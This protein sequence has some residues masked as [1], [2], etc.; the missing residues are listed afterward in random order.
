MKQ[1]VRKSFKFKA[2]FRD[3]AQKVLTSLDI[4]RNLTIGVHVRRSDM[5]S[6]RELSRGYNVATK[7]YFVKAF[8]YFRDKFKHLLFLVVSD[9]LNWCRSSIKG[10]DVRFVA[11][12]SAGS[13]M[14]LLS[15]CNHSVISTGSFGWWGAY[16]TGGE[17]VYYRNFP[18]NNSWLLKQYNKT[19]YYPL[20]W[21]GM[22]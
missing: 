21:I 2:D 10:D 13:D 17:V 22:E 7:E 6:K 11:T 4:G 16:L 9:D 14:A 15:Q 19:D 8:K 12:G 1:K 3:K 18:A 20:P 5:N